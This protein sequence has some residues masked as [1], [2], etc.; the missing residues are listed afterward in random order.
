MKNT[1]FVGW[2]GKA[3]KWRSGALTVFRTKKKAALFDRKPIGK[4]EVI[5][6]RLTLLLI[7]MWLPFSLGAQTIT[8]SKPATVT[9]AWDA[10]TE[11][12]VASY[13]LY[14]SIRAGTNILNLGSLPV[15]GRTNT[16]ATVTNV[17]GGKTYFT[18]T[19]IDNQGVES[20]PSTEVI[21]TNK[22]FQP[23]RLRIVTAIQTAAN[24]SGPWKTMTNYVV[25]PNTPNQFYRSQL[26]VEFVDDK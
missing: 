13:K 11:T 1:V 26:L 5:I 6:R 21:Y 20:E 16:T 14:W 17:G 7:S 8:N 9:L 4:V 18:V 24:A 23:Q 3:I 22:F 10:N 25:F 2:A 19:A 15:L 12:N